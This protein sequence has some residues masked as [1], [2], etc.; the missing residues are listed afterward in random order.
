MLCAGALMLSSQAHAD[1]AYTGPTYEGTYNE[2]VGANSSTNNTRSSI[3]AGYAGQD[4]VPLG[5]GQGTG[6]AGDTVGITTNGQ[7]TVHLHYKWNG[8]GT[9]TPLIVRVE[10]TP[11][12]SARS[13]VSVTDPDFPATEHVSVSVTAGGTTASDP[14]GTRVASYTPG[15]LKSLA[16]T[17]LK[18]LVTLSSGGPGSPIDVDLPIGYSASA[19][20][21]GGRFKA[22]PNNPKGQPVLGDV[23]AGWNGQVVRDKRSVNISRFGA[24]TPKLPTDPTLVMTKDE[25]VDANGTGHGNTIYSYYENVNAGRGTIRDQVVNTQSFVANLSPSLGSPSPPGWGSYVVPVPGSILFPTGRWSWSPSD[26]SDTYGSHSQDMPTGNTELHFQ[27]WSGSPTGTAPKIINYTITDTD[28]ATANARYNLT[29]H[30]PREIV[31]SSMTPHVAVNYRNDPNSLYVTSPADGAPV[32]GSITQGYSWTV[33]LNLT[34]GGE[35]LSK[36]FGFELA[37]SYSASVGT[38]VGTQ[39]NSVC[40]GWGAYVQVYDVVD[41][42]R[43]TYNTWDAHGFVSGPTAYGFDVP[44]SPVAGGMT[45]GPLT[46][47]GGGTQPPGNGIYTPP[48]APP[49]P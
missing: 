22:V 43:G 40:Q 20:L 49:H 35:D 27:K 3:T 24:P 5:G 47:L 6:Y 14:T 11:A 26:P 45:M 36:M 13:R 8:P 12:A 10:V 38:T 4:P 33:T 23:G 16:T 7:C 21:D 25:Y 17:N 28:G 29:L 15:V 19:T 41:Q 9:P 32:V 30:D 37:P 1:W 2:F 42:Y 48:I 46:W 44:S 39:Y 34:V 18:A 31:T